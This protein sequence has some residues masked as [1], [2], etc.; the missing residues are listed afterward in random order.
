M[1]RQVPFLDGDKMTQILDGKALSK[2]IRADLAAKI[3][4]HTS[5]GHRAPGLCTVLVGEDPAS[6]VYVRNKRKQA[7]KCGIES[8]HHQLDA[9]VSEQEL[10]DLIRDLNLNQ[11]IDGILVQ[12]PLP[13][14]I[15]DQK[16]IQSIDPAKDVDGFHPYNVGL[17]S[18]GSPQFVSCTPKGC[19]KL[20]ESSGISIKGSHAVVVGRSN[21]VGKPVASLLLSQ[22][23]TV[24][25]C[26]SR[27]KDLEAIT[28]Q[29]DIIIAAVGRPKFLGFDHIKD[30][31]VVIDVGINRGEDGKLVGDVDFDAV[32]E[33]TSAITPVPGGVGP[34][35]IAMLLENTLEAYESKL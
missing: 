10:L 4:A 5:N 27:T 17:L 35:T 22:H 12:L 24:T 7:T 19:M 11:K 23:A 29:A 26:H 28:R 9:S 1:T 14:H 15:D 6:E 33:N 13:K 16:I 3:Q 21:I 30:G 32:K 34:M 8:T 31:A 25:I 20:I 2:T 18:M